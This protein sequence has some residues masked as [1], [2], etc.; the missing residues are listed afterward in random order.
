MRRAST[1]QDQGGPRWRGPETNRGP[2]AGAAYQSALVLPKPAAPID[3]VTTI[4]R[5]LCDPRAP[6][7]WPWPK[8]TELLCAGSRPQS[9]ESCSVGTVTCRVFHMPAGN[10]HRASGLLSR[11]TPGPADAFSPATHLSFSRR[12]CRRRIGRLA[13]CLNGEWHRWQQIA[14]KP[15]STGQR[16]A[17][18]SSRWAC[19]SSGSCCSRTA[20]G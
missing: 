15:H 4:A 5:L 9:L 11:I 13:L 2:D 17:L 12:S 6:V 10:R 16:S 20:K 19:S 14:Q 8:R 1:R 3:Q 18:C 7:S